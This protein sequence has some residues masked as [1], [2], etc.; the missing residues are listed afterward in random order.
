[1]NKSNYIYLYDGSFE[2]LLNLINTLLHQ[3]VI[4]LD[5]KDETYQGNLFEEAIN[6]KITIDTKLINKIIKYLGIKIFNTMYYLYLSNNPHK[7][8]LIYYLE[9]YGFKYHEKVFFYRNISYID[10]IL[11]TVK[12][13]S[14]ELHK[15]KGF[16]RFQELENDVLVAY[17]APENNILPLIVKHFQKRLKNNNW[18]IVDKKRNM[19]A[20]YNKKDIL[21]KSYD[22]IK[23]NL[24]ESRDEQ[25]M[26]ELWQTFYKTIA[27]KERE[28]LICRR[29]F[30]PKKYWEYIVEVEKEL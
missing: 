14:R 16:L 21:I 20:I 7:E 26:V 3:K 28:N 6:L 30:M 29:N 27:I 19:G 8:L 13:V 25:Q 24:S 10:E 15:L 22:L 11:K 17:M 23:I 12:H 1:M 4:P 18:L 9:L 2:N 5:I